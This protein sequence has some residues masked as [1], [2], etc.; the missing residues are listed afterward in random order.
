MGY[1]KEL[2]IRK[3]LLRLYEQ[4]RGWVEQL[5]IDSEIMHSNQDCGLTETRDNVY[6]VK[7]IG[8]W[9]T[10]CLSCMSPFPLVDIETNAYLYYYSTMH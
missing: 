10:L 6:F 2:W 8:R 3:Y 5:R 4:N 9:W 1:L 7:G